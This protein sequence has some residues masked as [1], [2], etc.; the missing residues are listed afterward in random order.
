VVGVQRDGLM[1]QID[2]ACGPYR[3][4]SLISREAADELDLRPGDAATGGR[5]GDERRDP[6]VRRGARRPRSCWPR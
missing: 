6:P 2:L 4:V 1:A 5:Q 3:V